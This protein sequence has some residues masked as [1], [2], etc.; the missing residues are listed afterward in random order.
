MDFSLFS[1]QWIFEWAQLP[2]WKLV[3]LLFLNILWM[4]LLYWMLTEIW[5]SWNFW[6][7]GLY[8]L[9]TQEKILLAI[10][11]PRD[12]EQTPLSMEAIFNQI[13]GSHGTETWWEHHW[14]GEYQEWFS[15]EIVSIEGYVQYIVHCHEKFRDLVEAAVYAQ[16]PDAE[17]TEI[18]DY[19]QDVPTHYPNDEWDYFGV[20]YVLAKENAY[21]IRTYN[22]YE[23]KIRGEFI[24]PMSPLLEIMSKIGK[25]EQIWYQMII[26][27]IIEPDWQDDA[28]KVIDKL[29][30]K[31]SDEAKPKGIKG[32]ISSLFGITSKVVSDAIT[33]EGA[34]GEKKKEK[35]PQRTIMLTMTPG[36][37]LLVEEMERKTSRLAYKVRYRIMYFGQP[38]VFLKQRGTHPVIGAIKRFNDGTKNWFM[39]AKGTWTKTNYMF[40]KGRK[41]IRQRNLLKSYSKRSKYS[42][43]LPNGFVLSTEE[44][45]TIYH[46]PLATV[47]APLVKRTGARKSEPPPSLPVEDLETTAVKIANKSEPPA[48]SEP[49][50]DTLAETKAEPP[51]MEK[52]AVGAGTTI[53]VPEEKLPSLADK[54]AETVEDLDSGVTFIDIPEEP[55]ATQSDEPP[56][57]EKEA[58]ENESAGAPPANLPIE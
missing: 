8:K 29:V 50:A 22:E 16:Y 54:A 43:A 38:G 2:T 53:D 3:G 31:Q 19:T 30:E 35:D 28:Q 44:L 52:V 39:V 24:D 34:V 32:V 46:F 21:P 37:K 6:T 12:A 4:P 20:E 57:A 5:E 56:A 49:P 15:F 26:L 47:K 1:L 7:N 10:D 9:A 13:T 11:V 27:P 17:I 41:Y 14:D 36:E 58:V 40:K 48:V 18:R 23:D 51:A 25:G 45:A 55:P 42:G 33:P